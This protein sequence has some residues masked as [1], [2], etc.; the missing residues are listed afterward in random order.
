[1]VVNNFVP[2]KTL[3]ATDTKIVIAT[4]AM[5]ANDGYSKVSIGEIAADLGVSKGVINYHFH[6]KEI[7]L[8]ETVAYIYNQ[9]RQFMESQVWQTDNA[10]LQIQTFITLSCTYYSERGGL[11]KALQ[12]IRANFR[13]K[14]TKSL[15]V[16]LHERELADLEGVI[17]SGQKDNLFYSFD[18]KI[19]AITLRMALNGAAQ[20][21]M[22]AENTHKAA[23]LYA[24]E[25]RQ[26]F[27][28]AWCQI[29]I[30]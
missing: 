15:A 24:K 21:I 1:M 4:I 28:R 6:S 19:G 12:E 29:P 8:Q 22:S 14:Q 10:W 5:L 23:N 16:T 18:P 26:I 30:T 17:T 13:P 11:I 9:A 2:R 3:T 7:L 27:Q 25:L 20:Y